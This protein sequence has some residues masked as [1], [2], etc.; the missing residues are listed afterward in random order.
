[1]MKKH[2][3]KILT[4]VAVT[5]LAAVVAIPAVAQTEDPNAV[6]WDAAYWDNLSLSGTPDLQRTEIGLDQR[7][8]F[9]A[10]AAE[11][12]AN[13]FSARWTADVLF[14]AG[15]Y[16]FQTQ[17]DDGIRV[18]VDGAPVIDNWTVHSL[19]TDTG[20]IELTEGVHTV[21]VEYFEDQG[22]AVAT[23][24]WQQVETGG[25]QPGQVEASISPTS[26][27]PGTEV[28]VTAVGFPSNIGV[29]VGAGPVASEYTITD[30]A[31]TNVNGV[32]RTTVT[33]PETATP[34]EQWVAVVV[35]GD[36]ALQAISN[37]FTVLGLGGGEPTSPCG[38][39]YIVAVGDTLSEIAVECEVSLDALIA[40]ND[41]ILNPNVI[42]P[43]ERLTIPGGEPGVTDPEPDPFESVTIY[44]A[45]LGT[46]DVGCGDSI[47]S[48]TVD[49]E[50]TTTPLITSI[51]T[52]FT[53]VPT[54]FNLDNPLTAWDVTVADVDLT[55]T[56][57]TIALEGDI[58]LGGTCDIPR[59]EAILEQTALQYNTI[60]TVIYTINGEPL[61]EALR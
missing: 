52:L 58:S 44:V 34:G 59:A 47:V 46:G 9:G 1:M 17:S 29:E 2:L 31:E 42:I 36:D 51:E 14:D 10:P 55:G 41:F 54:G 16:R 28:N 38:S 33:I 49:V 23:L 5:V 40:A 45:Q 32:V 39:T 11:I 19:Q 15:T 56:T 21:R 61:D 53:Y 48:V 60:D 50:P 6:V 8:G 30:L 3:W 13:N 4:A 27:P 37:E 20:F 24:G 26:G 25:D 18:F 43:G 22:T 12:P 57:A 7:W 35:S